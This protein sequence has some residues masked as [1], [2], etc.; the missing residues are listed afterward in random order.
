[1]YSSTLS[2]TTALEGDEGSASRPDRSLPPGKNPVPIVYRRL[3][4]PQGRSGQVRKISPPTGI[5]SPDP[6]A[7]SQSLYRLSYP[8]HN[9]SYGHTTIYSYVILTLRMLSASPQL[10]Q[11]PTTSSSN[12]STCQYLSSVRSRTYCTVLRTANISQRNKRYLPPPRHPD[13]AK[14]LF[15]GFIPDG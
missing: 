4:G 14:V 11:H 10:N 12:T 9:M 6:P 7:R 1:M 13:P 8:T 5:R 3:G 15:A 2:L